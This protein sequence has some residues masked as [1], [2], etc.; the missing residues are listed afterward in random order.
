M[1][2]IGKIYGSHTL[3]EDLTF[4]SHRGDR[5]AI[6]GANGCGKTTLIKVVTGEELPDTGRVFW[7]KAVEYA[8]Y[9]RIFDELDL[10]DTVSHAVNVVGGAPGLAFYAPRRVVHRFLSLFQFSELDLKKPITSLSAGQKARVALMQCLLC[11]A[12]VIFLD[13]PTNHLD[14]ASAQVMERNLVNLPGAVVVAS[15]DRFFIDKVAN[16]LLI[17][18]GEGHIHEVG[19]NWT[20]WQA[21]LREA[22]GLQKHQLPEGPLAG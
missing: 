11:G 9:N 15:H 3:F 12:G 1:E 16:R 13:E 10:N 18:D 7:H 5:T 22:S 14:L 19:G 2:R 4:E 6:T 17:F 8:D 20:I 21:S